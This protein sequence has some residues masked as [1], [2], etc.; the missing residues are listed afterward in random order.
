MKTRAFIAG[1]AGLELTPDEV[2]FF[3]RPILGVSSSFA[4]TWRTVSR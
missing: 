3:R 1:C 4:A 2:A